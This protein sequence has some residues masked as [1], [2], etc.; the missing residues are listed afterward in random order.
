M[1]LADTHALVWFVDGQPS[2]GPLARDIMEAALKDEGGHVS[3]MSFWELAMLHAKR[4]LQFETSVTAWRKATLD[5]GFIEI[6]VTGD[7]GIA[8]AELSGF[9]SDPADRFI[10]AAA[11]Q[12][13][14]KLITADQRILD[15]PGQV[16]RHD[17]RL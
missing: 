1:I 13:G 10:V 11:L 8:A 14:L 16:S 12:N 9:H 15:W 2:L 3:A 17:A 4:R 6:P 7:I 5:Q